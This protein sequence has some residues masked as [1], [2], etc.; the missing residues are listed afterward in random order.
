MQLN[1]KTIAYTTLAIFIITHIRHHSVRF[2]ALSYELVPGERLP[3]VR[4]LAADIG[5]NLHTVNKAYKEL[6]QKGF[7][8]NHHQKGVVVNPEGVPKADVSFQEEMKEILHLLIAEAICR[9][10]NKKDIMKLCE[11]IFTSYIH[12]GEAKR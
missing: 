7:N 9:D 12:E 10:V 11:E 1:A 4:S 6:E 8:L 5:I 3:Y 2:K